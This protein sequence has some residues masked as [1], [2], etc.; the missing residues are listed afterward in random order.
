VYR[1]THLHFIIQV[2]VLTFVR[3]CSVEH[4]ITACG[5]LLVCV[6]T[7][8]KDTITN[9]WHCFSKH[10]SLQFGYHGL[11]TLS[12]THHYLELVSW[13]VVARASVNIYPFS[14]A[15]VVTRW[16]WCAKG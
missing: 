11:A 13:A 6:C 8:Y 14:T 15:L 3:H 1:L 5:I 2:F 10:A 9:G 4:Y 12:L 16:A 7:T